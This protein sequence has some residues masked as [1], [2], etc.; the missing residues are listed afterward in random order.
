MSDADYTEAEQA[1]EEYEELEEQVRR[2]AIYNRRRFEGLQV[3]PEIDF[4]PEVADREPGD[5]NIVRFGF[6]LHPQVTFWSAGFLVVFLGYALFFQEQ[7]SDTL[8]SVLGFVNG[9]FGWFFIMAANIIVLMAAYFAFSRFGKIRIGGP[10]ARPEFSTGAW[11]AMLI[12]AGMGIGL[13]FWSVAE[14]IFHVSSP[15]PFFGV[16]PNTG[17]AGEA[18]LATTFFHW[19]LHPWSIYALVSLGLA[20]F[21]Y[22][23][24]LPLTFRSVFY[25]VLGKRIYGPWGNAIDI[26]TVLATLFGLATSLGFGVQQVSAGFNFL[27]G[28]PDNTGFQVLLIALITGAATLSVVAGLDGG[29]KRLSQIN[30][31]L[32]LAFMVFILIVGPTLFILSVFT[33]SL[34]TYVGALPALSWWNEAFTGTNWQGSWTVFYWAWWISWSPFVGMFIARISKGRTVRELIL[35]VVAFPSMLSFFWMS[36]FG[37]TALNLQ[38]EGIR[39]VATAVSENVA[40]ALFDM[41]EAFPL[42]QVTSLLGVVLVISFFVTSSD[43]GSLV[44]DHLTSGGKLDSPV[45]QRVFWA[46]ME[47]AIAAIL[48]L[49]GGLGALQTAA[50]ATGLPFAAVLLLMCWSIYTAFDQELDLLEGHYDAELFRSRHQ[51]LLEHLGVEQP[52]ETTKEA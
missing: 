21:A 31:Y 27:F 29:V 42:T 8:N 20:F 18:A 24:G 38:L 48:L 51:G 25:P 37:G 6:D 33:E 13:M 36:V 47:G 10:T 35:G 14:P 19:G 41:L 44:V 5:S 15:A 30:I 3:D 23:R 28:W 45:P 39:D 1:Y 46:I 40:T 52:T 16:E 22:N 34:G 11:Y 43:S 9:T 26:L 4:Y 50:V 49:G 7:A 12:S 17:P 32:A 2:N